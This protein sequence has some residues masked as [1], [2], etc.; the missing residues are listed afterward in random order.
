MCESVKIENQEQTKQEEGFDTKKPAEI[1]VQS[2]S[3]CVQQKL[4]LL[5]SVH[6]YRP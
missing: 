5:A 6:V 1:L 4:I 3:V 2:P